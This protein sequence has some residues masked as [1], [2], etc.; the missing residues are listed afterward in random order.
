MKQNKK[1]SNILYDNIDDIVKIYLKEISSFPTLTALEEIELAK[2]IAN[3]DASA[4]EHFINCNLRLVVSI[5]RKFPTTN[6]DF[7]DL[8]QEGN[9]GLIKAVERYDYTKGIKFSTY[10]TYWITQTISRS[11]ADKGYTIRIPVYIKSLMKKYHTVQNDFFLNNSRYATDNEIS[12][13]MKI[14]MDELHNLKI[15]MYDFVSLNSPI[16]D[17]ESV[18][19]DTIICNELSVEDEV[20]KKSFIENLNL[21]I[22]ISNLTERQ[23]FVIRKRYNIA[24][25]KF[26]TL[27]C[28]GDCLN[29]SKEQILYFE[30]AA[31]KKMIE[32]NQKYHII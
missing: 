17:D 5:A 27:Q 6:F 18:L 8:I 25:D 29:V 2:K 15:H 7:L 26:E 11:I 19:E 30:R 32:V 14:S 21:L 16:G 1:Q 10:A 3:N 12:E 31:L 13:L 28:I 22:S 9:L 20:L 4:K 23:E 24:E